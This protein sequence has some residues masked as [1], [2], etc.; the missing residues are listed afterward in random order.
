MGILTANQMLFFFLGVLA[1][2]FIFA[3][4]YLRRTYPFRW[5]STILAVLGIMLALFSIAWSISS[6]LENESRASGMGL[7][8]FGVTSLICL[9]L[10]RQLVVKELKLQKQ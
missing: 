8:V 4:V 1:T 6:L 2:L 9:G 10:A 3:L 5:H 7:L